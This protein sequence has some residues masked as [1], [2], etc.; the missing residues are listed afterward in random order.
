[1]Y[2]LII[3]DATTISADG[4]YVADVAVK[5]GK[6]VYVGPRPR[7]RAHRE[8]NAIGQFLIP[9]LIDTAVQFNATNS[10]SIWDIETSAAVTGG[11]TTVLA[12]PPM[13]TP[14]QTAKVRGYSLIPRPKSRGAITACGAPPFSITP[15]I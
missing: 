8:L 5:D 9:G 14:S 10:G 3:R 12:L 4:R 2:D 7:Q 1:M 15:E 11:V 13:P 6:I